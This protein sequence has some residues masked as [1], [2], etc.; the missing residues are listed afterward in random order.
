MCNELKSNKYCH[1]V[2]DC[3]GRV[4]LSKQAA[5]RTAWYK[6]VVANRLLS[7]ATKMYKL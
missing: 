4:G 6:R 1:N 3:G 5:G 7:L 2:I